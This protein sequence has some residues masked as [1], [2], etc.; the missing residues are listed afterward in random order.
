[1]SRRDTPT[2]EIERELAALDAAL[3]GDDTDAELAT[4]VALVRDDRPAVDPEFARELDEW[5]AEGFPRRSGRASS[6]GRG[7]FT[8]PSFLRMRPLVPALGVAA[9]LL[10]GLVVATSVVN[11]DSGDTI[12]DQE[13]NLAAPKSVETTKAPQPSVVPESGGDAGRSSSEPLVPGTTDNESGV[14]NRK[15]R[16]QELS[17]SLSLNAPAKKIDEVS[18][19]VL[20][21]TT[22]YGGVVMRSDIS[23]TSGADFD[24]R[25]PADK[26]QPA[27]AA[28]SELGEVQSRNQTSTD[29]TAAFVSP[30]ERLTD[31]LAERK[32]LLKQLAKADTPN[33]TASI[34]ERLRLVS[35]QIAVARGELRGLQERANFAKVTV[36]VNP[37]NGSSDDGGAGSWG[38]GDGLDDALRI[39]AWTVAALIVC[40][41]VAL[42]FLVIGGLGAGAARALRRRRREQAL[43]AV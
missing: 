26:L 32:A 22:R 28:L 5:A 9:T 35:Q 40:L 4:I 6:S 16:K 11:N 10:I 3:A 2:P 41:A 15:N 29:I 31:G 33:E 38:I 8:L 27:L 7:R 19:G 23:S 21:T 14:P 1:M 36:S 18:A 43:D 42:P 17:A 12:V 39:L 25:I 24:L 30:R 37:K 13:P 34:R 20:K